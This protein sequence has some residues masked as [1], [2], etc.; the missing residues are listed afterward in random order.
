MGHIV[1][2]VVVSV[3]P[4]LRIIQPGLAGSEAWLAGPQAWLAGPQA[5]LDGP[6]GGTYG[7][8]YIRKIS[9]FYRTSSPIGAAAQKLHIWGTWNHQPNTARVTLKHLSKSTIFDIVISSTFWNSSLFFQISTSI[10]VKLF[11]C[12][13]KIHPFNLNKK[14]KKK[15]DCRI[16]GV[17][18]TE[19]IQM[20]VDI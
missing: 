16:A 9:P 2:L 13:W 3:R 17:E 1:C 18:T 19:V 4:S 20:E 7:R 11:T 6:E 14:S 10:H 12:E 5:W 15:P 8:T